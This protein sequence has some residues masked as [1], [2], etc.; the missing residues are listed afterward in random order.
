MLDPALGER[1]G[2][3]E[4]PLGGLS[5]SEAAERR[6]RGLGNDVPETHTRSV[7]A[8][9]RSN[10]FTPFNAL[11]GGLLAVILVVGPLQ[12]ALF[13]IVLVANTLTGIVQ[14]YR[15]KRT[16]DRLMVLTAPK[17]RVVRGGT[18]RDAAVGEVVQGDV[19]EL[20]PGD[21]IVVD[22]EVIS[23]GG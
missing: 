23:A 17:A 21:Q 4:S 22:G 9:V 14:E 20:R 1:P 7:G 3:E 5:D 15:A 11:L 13:G 12:D 2:S 10:V 6:A 18:I 16:L 19:L 8:I